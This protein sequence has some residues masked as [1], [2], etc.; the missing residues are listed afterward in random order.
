MFP[1]NTRIYI[2]SAGRSG[3]VCTHKAFP[4]SL[5]EHVSFV[6]PPDQFKDYRKSLSKH[7]DV[8]PVDK[9]V[10]HCLPPQRQWLFDTSVVRFVWV[11]D[12]DLVFNVRK[13]GTTQ[14]VKAEPDEVE[15]AFIHCTNAITSTAKDASPVAQVGISPRGGNNRVEEP[16]AELT[17]CSRCY[18]VDT[19]VF[20]ALKINIAP[21]DNFV[22]EDFHLSLCLLETG[23]RNRVYYTWA[24][25]DLGSN[26]AGGCSEYRTFEVQK[27]SAYWLSLNHPKVVET[28]QKKTSGSWNGFKKDSS[29]NNTRVDVRISWS[30]AFKQKRRSTN[31]GIGAFI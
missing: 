15:R 17:R 29:G 10:P 19:K 4:K 28:V 2:N 11:M 3:I 18:C 13:D 8:I 24:Q 26:T 5:R 30:K 20:R 23:Y 27:K 9:D 1:S 12:D 7:W 6:V 25:G 31:K 14:L 16:Y 22:M 21:I